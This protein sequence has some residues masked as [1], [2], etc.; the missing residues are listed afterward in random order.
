MSIGYEN[1][2]VSCGLLKSDVRVDVSNTN[3][4]QLKHKKLT[5]VQYLLG[6]Y[7]ANKSDIINDHRKYDHKLVQDEHDGDDIVCT[8][9]NS[10][11]TCHQLKQLYSSNFSQNYP[12]LFDSPATSKSDT[13]TNIVS[14]RL[15]SSDKSITQTIHN[16]IVSNNTT[17]AGSKQLNSNQL[18]G[19]ESRL[20]KTS[21]YNGLLRTL[22]FLYLSLLISNQNALPCYGFRN[23]M[24]SDNISFVG[25]HNVSLRVN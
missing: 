22:T 15:E 14:K 9:D 18:Q 23:P 16:G 8:D 2:V 17:L 12:Y 24:Y 4:Y 3:S 1:C 5:W 6:F 20:F 13:P 10:I 19:G 11:L 21:Q 25:N 7:F